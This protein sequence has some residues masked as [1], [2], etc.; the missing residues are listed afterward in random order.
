M[1]TPLTAQ[2]A[3]PHTCST[4]H[5]HTHVHADQEMDMEG[6]CVCHGAHTPMASRALGVHFGEAPGG[7]LV[8]VAH[9]QALVWQSKGVSS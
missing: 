5:W 3:V 1:D 7:L 6:L 9:V 2:P 4:G 8:H